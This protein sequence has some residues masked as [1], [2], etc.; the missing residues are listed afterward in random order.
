[1][2]WKKLNQTKDFLCYE[3]KS[4]RY[5]VRIE[6]RFEESV[7]KV[8]KIYFDDKLRL[9]ED[10]IANDDRRLKTLLK[11]LMDEKDYTK[12]RVEQKLIQKKSG[13]TI[14]LLR[15][16]KEYESEKWFFGINGAE[17]ENTLIIHFGDV[18]EM[19]M[20]INEDCRHL[21]GD[22][23][24]E[25]NRSLALADLEKEINI[26]LFSHRFIKLEKYKKPGFLYEKIEL[27]MEDDDEQS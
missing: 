24:K 5:N 18:I 3:K 16:Y 4:S 25:I 13:V 6:A 2:S 22:I 10:F 21:L 12:K 15:S 1:M 26:H 8:Y 14:A 9:V 20:I 7:W 17:K 23:I 19:D 11:K 27:D